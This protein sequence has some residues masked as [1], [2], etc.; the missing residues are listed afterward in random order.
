MEAKDVMTTSVITVAP[1]SR[2]DDIAALLI[3]KHISAVP[4]MDGESI[5]GI[6]S[7]G[8]FLHRHETGT[9]RPHPWWSSL[10]TLPEE[11]AHEYVKAHGRTARDV[12][13]GDVVV[14]AE[15]TPLSEV[16]ETL[17]KHRIKRVP[18]LR[19]GKLV[20]IVSRAD[21]LQG[22]VA[23]RGDVAA[24]SNPDDRTIRERLVEEL[25]SETDIRVDLISVVVEG[26]VVHLGGLV[27]SEAE[28]DAVRVAAENVPGVTAVV[29]HTV[30][31]RGLVSV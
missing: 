1:D 8:D 13:T 28:R 24:A 15:T 16:A 27:D 22:L 26:G 17:E 7:E 20:G 14:V 21:L 10:I 3:E 18:V 25:A 31:R 5:V 6:V 29:N 4:V 9:E 30:L 19:D 2:V 12:M 23:G 11:R